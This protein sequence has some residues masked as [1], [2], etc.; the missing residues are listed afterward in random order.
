M[1]RQ[2]VYDKRTKKGSAY[3]V[4]R[5]HYLRD[6][7]EVPLE[8]SEEDDFAQVA[9][10]AP[11]SRLS[12]APYGMRYLV[13]DT[14][15]ILRQMD[16]LENS[17]DALCN[18]VLMQTV[19]EEVKHRDLSLYNRLH[20][21][22]S[23]M[24]RRFVVF[25]NEHHRDTYVQRE[26][27]E[28]MNDRNDRA[29]RVAAKW[30]SGYIARPHLASIFEANGEVEVL[31]LTDDRANRRLA[32]EAGIKAMTITE[33]VEG[34]K[35]EFPELEDLLARR[36]DD[37]DKGG[38]SKRGGGGKA[39]GGKAGGGKAGGKA[40][41]GRGKAVGGKVKAG[42]DASGA[43]YPAHLT[44]TELS[45][46][47]KAGRIYQ[48]CFRVSRHSHKEGRVMVNNLPGASADSGAPVIIDGFTA[49]N[50]ATDGD[51]VAV[52]LFEGDEEDGDE[53]E[54]KSALEAAGAGDDDERGAEEDAGASVVCVGGGG[55]E[56]VEASEGGGG[57][58]GDVAEGGSKAKRAQK[59]R[60]RVVGIV[61]R[62]W[63]TFC[64][65]LQPEDGKVQGKNALFVPVER[66]MPKVKITTR[67]REALDN[68]RILVAIDTWD[69]FSRF[70]QGH[71]VRTI[72]PIG[73]KKTETE[74]LLIEHNIPTAEFSEKVRKRE[75]DKGTRAPLCAL[76]CGG[77][78]G[79]AL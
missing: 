51:I 2:R 1:L 3:R 63:R 30:L 77:S 62:S 42:A 29:I 5:E 41:A 37:G 32:K 75:D 67:Q 60:G 40:G 19:M 26:A 55:G 44:D 64:G 24:E 15:I 25:S 33:Y 16:L 79:C 23:V 46:A 65:S 39:G 9:G 13:P 10:A 66:R 72:G 14:N 31:H 12:A 47:L 45:R 71:Y 48:G 73:D 18:V 56:G 7:I 59:A 34:V 68:M 35:K 76:C 43:L 78:S 74:V 17:C 50:R 20:A 11:Q 61:R 49:M 58:G 53:G 54:T 8:G 4:V 6:D 69:R 22:I 36:S 52:E 28:S 21:L 57:N 38:E 27:G 70:P